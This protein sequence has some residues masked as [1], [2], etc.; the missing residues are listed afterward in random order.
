MAG[1]LSFWP[2]GPQF[3]WQDKSGSRVDEKT[4]LPFFVWVPS[5]KV[6]DTSNIPTIAIQTNKVRLVDAFRI[7]DA[8]VVSARFKAIIEEFEP[9][10]HQ[11]FPVELRRKDGTPYEDSYFIFHPTRMAPCVLLSKSKI[12]EIVRVKVGP[13]TGLPNYHVRE[14]EYVIS[15]PAFGERKVFG[16]L[17]LGGG[18]GDALFVSDAVMARMKAK[19]LT[20]LITY[21]VEERDEPWVFEKEAP[22]L[23]E[24]LKDKPEIAAEYY[25]KY[26]TVL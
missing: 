7:M 17:F 9:N 13:R 12:S 4:R 3:E 8:S 1:Y 21:P 16:S 14:D 6:T 10:V 5:P 19:K 25:E 11:F 20:N 23:V 15:R 22:E 24:F 18:G 2:E 26:L